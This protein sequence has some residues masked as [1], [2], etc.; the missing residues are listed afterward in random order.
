M[1][2]ERSFIVTLL[3]P[4]REFKNEKTV[5]IHKNKLRAYHGMEAS[6]IP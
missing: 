5:D 3:L 1:T 4:S 6:V 2:E